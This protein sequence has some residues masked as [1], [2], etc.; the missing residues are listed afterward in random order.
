V[1]AAREVRASAPKRLHNPPVHSRF[2]WVRVFALYPAAALAACS[3]KASIDL[4]STP[5][6]A[7]DAAQ[8]VSAAETD[9]TL[10]DEAP[11]ALGESSSDAASD[12]GDDSE[13]TDAADAAEGEEPNE[14]LPGLPTREDGSDAGCVATIA[15][16][17][18]LPALH[19]AIGSDIQWDSNPPSSGPHYPI[20]AAYQAYDD[21]VPRGYYVHDLEH[22]AIVFV[23]NCGDAGCP[24]VVAAFHAASDS[25]PDDPLC[26]AAGEGVRVRTVITPDPLLDVTVA[27]AA[28]GWTYKAEC[29]DLPSLEA[30][31]A[32]HYGQGPEVFCTNGTT[33]F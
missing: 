15:S 28:W 9:G 18:L 22:G 29:I 24:D 2:G 6:G 11:S 1:T 32:A 10:M 17:P 12:G 13:P 4:G 3:A 20:W 25:L 26:T 5:R 16:P 19:V 33:Q 31:A 21:P 23:F 7:S 8:A 30:F 14:A 27:A